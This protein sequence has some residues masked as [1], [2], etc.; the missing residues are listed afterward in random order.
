MKSIINRPLPD[1]KTFK[2]VFL[3]NLNLM[4]KE[5]YDELEHIHNQERVQ[6][7]NLYLFAVLTAILK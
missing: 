3:R 6:F 5:N 1:G 2:N 4:K 7:L